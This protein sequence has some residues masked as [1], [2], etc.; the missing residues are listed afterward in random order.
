IE[1][2]H[3][4]STRDDAERWTAGFKDDVAGWRQLRF[5]FSSLVRKEIGNGAPND[6]LALTEVHGWALGALNTGGP[7]RYF[8][9][10]VTL[11][12]AAGVRP[13][14]VAF[15]SASLGVGEGGTATAT[16][17]LSR[18]LGDAD[19]EEVTVG[20]SLVPGTATPDRD[21][22]PGGGRLTF[23]RA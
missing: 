6:G 21:Y 10:Q 20:Y 1:N 14:T 7:R 22:T 16:V 4:G 18:P 23:A 5:P 11:F 12:G 8:V 13:L 15:T 2:R 17:R 19:P 3:P 9:D